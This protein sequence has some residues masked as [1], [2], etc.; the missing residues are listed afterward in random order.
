MAYSCDA[1]FHVFIFT[2]EEHKN[3]VKERLIDLSHIMERIIETK[4]G[5]SGTTII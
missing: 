3:M 4:I 1:G 5:D 2:F